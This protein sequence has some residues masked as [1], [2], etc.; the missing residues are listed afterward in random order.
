M[1]PNF[2]YKDNNTGRKFRCN[3]KKTRC[4]GR[5]RA[6][7]R[8]KRNTIKHW[9]VCFQHLMSVH[10]VQVKPS[11]IPGAGL[12]LFAARDFHRNEQIGPYIG[13]KL[14]TAQIDARYGED[15]TAPYAL[16]TRNDRYVDSACKRGFTAYINHSGRPNSRFVLYRGKARVVADI[17][18]IREGREI[19]VSYGPEYRLNEPGVSYKTKPYS[20]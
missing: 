16:K 11:N 9:D 3:L 10:G 8:C 2:N 4:R 6:G 18:L 13:D 15:N 7:D 20:T 14:T 19:T 1:P 12:G 5:T 17:N